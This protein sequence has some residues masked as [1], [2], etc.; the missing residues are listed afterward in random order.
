LKWWVRRPQNTL[1]NFSCQDLPII[2][3]PQDL[4]ALQ[5]LI[6]LIKADLLIETGIVNGATVKALNNA[7]WREKEGELMPLISILIPAKGRPLYARDAAFSAIRQNFDDFDVTFSNNGAEP[8]VKAA[9]AEF[10]SDPRFHYIE[11]PSVLDMPSH[12]DLANQAVTGDYILVLTDRSV[13]KQGVLQK[14]STLLGNGSGNVDIASW[15]FDVFKNPSG[16]LPVP[17][18]AR[19][20]RLKTSDELLRFARGEMMDHYWTLPRGLNSCIS[21]S[22]VERIRNR[23]GHVFQ[24]INPDYRFAFSCLLNANEQVHFD[25][26]FFIFQGEELSNGMKALRGDARPYLNSL[27]LAEPWQDVPIKAALVYNTIEQDFLAA[28]REYRRDDIRSEWNTSEYYLRCLKEI[29]IKRD[30]AVLS[31]SEIGEL[32]EAVEHS[33]Q[34]EH[35]SV[36][37]SVTNPVRHTTPMTRRVIRKM[38]YLT[39]TVV[40]PGSRLLRGLHQSP[41]DEKTWRTILEVAGF[42]R[43]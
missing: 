36:R 14:L 27:G 42:G 41:K 38:K 9:V 21:R 18:W 31:T 2:Q 8:A 22:L 6:W 39:K 11:Q 35:E 40:G 16:L 7:C 24:K 17:D 20:R 43:C 25:E 19:M 3:N 23:E 33:L 26:A 4:V 15:R 37:A 13:L 28:L 5:K 34:N 12:W 29:E 32:Q 10:A 1:I 30:A